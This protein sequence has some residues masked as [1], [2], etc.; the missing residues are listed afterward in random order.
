MC[1]FYFSY[2]DINSHKIL[3]LSLFMAHVAYLTLEN[4]LSRQN[5]FDIKSKLN[6]IYLVSMHISIL[7]DE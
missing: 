4:S 1:V 7:F 2:N 6:Y 3:D 5:K